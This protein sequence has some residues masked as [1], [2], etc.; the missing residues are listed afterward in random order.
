MTREP[1]PDF[2]RYMIAL[3]RGE[4]DRVP[5]GDWHVD[6]SLKARFLGRNLERI[7][8][9]IDFCYRAGFDYVPQFAGL[10]TWPHGPAQSA[11]VLRDRKV[12][13]DGDQSERVWAGERDNVVTSWEQFKKYTWPTADDFKFSQ[14]KAL[15][16]LLP[17]GMKAIPV[18]GRIFT[19]VWL[20]MGADN[21]FDALGSN[22]E[23]VAALFDKIGNLQY[24]TL[25]RLTEHSSVGA[26]VSNDD[27]A[28]NTGLLIHPKYLR[29]YMFP[30]YQKFG[31]VCRQQGWG[32][33]FHSDGEISEI[34]DDIIACGFDG[35]HP[36]QPN[37]MDIVETKKKWGDRLCLL[38]NINLDSTL[39]LGTPEDVRSEVYERIRTVGPGG[40]YMVASS[41]S[42][43]N[44]VPFENMKAMFN[45]TFEFGKYPIQLPDRGYADT[46]FKTRSRTEFQQKVESLPGLNAADYVRVF[47]DDN[48][49]EAIE[50]V[51]RHIAAGVKPS[52]VL[53]KGMVQAMA[54]IGGKFQSGEIYIPEM[55]MAARTM[56]STVG[57]FKDLLTA[58]SEVVSGRVV[59]G[60]VKGDLHDIGKNLVIM[61]LEGQGLTVHDLGIGVH[62]SR[63]VEAVR[64]EKPDV[65]A[66][67]ALLTSTM[68]E[69]KVVIDALTNAG[70]RDAVK[71]IVGGAPVTAE[72]AARIGADAYAFDA[73]EAAQK[74]KELLSK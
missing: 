29:K 70:L 49:P 48:L 73:P 74:C 59:M 54:I 10:L 46:T 57:H 71:I 68:T 26:I 61:M 64:D 28:H 17:K 60:T 9:E 47:L 36:V 12:S 23:L 51:E 21:F 55:I 58:K 45:A 40:G 8:D 72:F 25:L 33:V 66:M 63:F 16:R 19:S 7:E 32:F 24:E 52:D 18:L 1:N 69:M 5:L 34:M 56:S 41:N 42:V 3:H 31:E 4:P 43:T 44:Y 14:F 30:W 50:L 38:G 62:E 35:F 11:S 53:S 2:D 27:C 22:E 13:A 20:Y 39:T 37:A 6:T 65:L 67:S 15:D